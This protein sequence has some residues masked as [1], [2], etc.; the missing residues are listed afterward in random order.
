M[1]LWVLWLQLCHGVE[2]LRPWLPSLGL[3]SERK[4]LLQGVTSRSNKCSNLDHGP[5]CSILAY[6]LL[7]L[8][9]KDGSV[10]K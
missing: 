2:A 10:D 1:V 3:G 9:L 7:Y 6:R 8:G 5:V 4:V